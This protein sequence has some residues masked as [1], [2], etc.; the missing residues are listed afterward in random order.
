MEEIKEKSPEQEPIVNLG[1]RFEEEMIDE[2]IKEANN[3]QTQCPDIPPLLGIDTPESA[4]PQISQNQLITQNVDGD[5]AAQIAE[6]MEVAE[7]E[8]S[9]LVS[10]AIKT[11]FDQLWEQGF[12]IPVNIKTTRRHMDP[13]IAL[14]M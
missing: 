2:M 3:T 10:D 8:V 5:E 6:E 9:P 13:F 1:E 4:E 7:E 14:Q 11:C 12:H